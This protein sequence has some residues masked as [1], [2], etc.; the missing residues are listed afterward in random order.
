[1]E[2]E[3]EDSYK[4]QE[5]KSKLIWSR[6]AYS[7]DQIRTVTEIRRN[8]NTEP[9]QAAHATLQKHLSIRPEEDNEYTQ[10]GIRK[11][12]CDKCNEVDTAFVSNGKRFRN[13]TAVFRPRNKKNVYPYV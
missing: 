8:T 4:T 9:V 7:G 2:Q 10:N 3:T 13:L 11:L 6:L 12:K 1:M 5:R